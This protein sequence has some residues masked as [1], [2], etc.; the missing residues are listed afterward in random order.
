MLVTARIMTCLATPLPGRMNCGKTATKKSRRPGLEIC[1][2][3]PFVN[4]LADEAGALADTETAAPELA[5]VRTPSPI[6]YAAP[7]QVMTVNRLFDPSSTAAMPV[8]DTAKYSAFAAR[9][10]QLLH[11]EAN[12]PRE[13]PCDMTSRTAGPGLKQAIVSIIRKI[14]QTLI[15]IF[16]RSPSPNLCSGYPG[17]HN[18]LS[19][20]WVRIQSA[21]TR[22]M[23]L[24]NGPGRR[25][26]IYRAVRARPVA[27][28]CW[29]HSSPGER[30]W[31]HL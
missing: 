8:A 30:E 20:K 15:V 25:D 5:N 23:R 7:T 6:V 17:G 21:L 11:I 14:I 18:L 10:P 31:R 4:I 26:L 13:S 24:S 29:R 3:N 28:R 27:K 9:I 12:T 2:T 19:A 1:S 16:A 22:P